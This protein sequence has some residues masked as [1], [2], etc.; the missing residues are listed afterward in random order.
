MQR[1]RSKPVKSAERAFKAVAKPRT[2][3]KKRTEEARQV[4]EEYMENLKAFMKKL[5]RQSKLH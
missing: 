4:L 5:F 3:T 1:T 2:S